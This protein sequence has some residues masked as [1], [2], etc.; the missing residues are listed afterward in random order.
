MPTVPGLPAD[1]N[2][3]RALMAGEQLIIDWQN[4]V[5]AENN[6][7]RMAQW[8]AAA[9]ER[10]DNAPEN[11]ERQNGLLGPDTYRNRITGESLSAGQHAM[12]LNELNPP[13]LNV[14]TGSMTDVANF[15]SDLLQN[16]LQEA[17]L[18]GGPTGTATQKTATG[19]GQTLYNMPWGWSSTNQQN[20]QYVA[21]GNGGYKDLNAVP[22]L[23]G[24]DRQ[25]GIALPYKVPVPGLMN[26]GMAK[27]PMV[28]GENGPEL[29]NAPMG[30]SVTPIS[31]P[32]MRNLLMNGLPG[33]ATGTNPWDALAYQAPDFTGWDEV[34]QQQGYFSAP[35]VFNAT[36][37][38]PYPGDQPAY[39]APVVQPVQQPAPVATTADDRSTSSTSP[40]PTHTQQTAPTGYGTPAPQQVMTGLRTAS[41]MFDITGLMPEEQ[42]L[43][44]EVR[45]VRESTP[46]PDIGMSPYSV[47]WQ[48]LTPSI[49][50]AY[51]K[52]MAAKRG[53]NPGDFAFEIDRNQ[54]MMPGLGRGQAQVSY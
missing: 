54:A 48:L 12:R 46:V 31:R 47:G 39:T 49:R 18:T 51:L 2:A 22:T 44:D 34:P 29:V 5:Q 40:Y 8:A 42:S 28:V 33:Y 53:I 3:R 21:D 1:P 52:G 19:F 15:N 9:K 41:G 26:G 45:R 11:W 32:T 14:N 6:P 23:A 35:P 37:T 10:A 36:Y 24:D 20:H 38:A 25:R 4:R 13:Q 30:A 7:L 16:A 50:E 17:G 27:G 43:L